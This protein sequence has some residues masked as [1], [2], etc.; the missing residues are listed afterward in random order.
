MKLKT[1]KELGKPYQESFDYLNNQIIKVLSKGYPELKKVEFVSGDNKESWIRTDELKQEAI[2]WIKLLNEHQG[3]VKCDDG[4][5]FEWE[6]SVQDIYV[7]KTWIKHFFNI[8]E[9]DLK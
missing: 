2:K 6:G 4:H 7:L 5:E 9:D 3:K 1:L 8:T